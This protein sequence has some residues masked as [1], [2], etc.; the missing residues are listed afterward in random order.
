MSKSQRI[1]IFVLS[2]AL[3]FVAYW[4]S[5]PLPQVS[6]EIQVLIF[7]A[8]IM[9]SFTSL[10]LEH[11]FTTPTDVVA[12]TV[13]IL[14]VLLPLR[15]ILRPMA[16]YYTALV[17][18]SLLLLVTSM[19][20]LLLLDESAAST[21]A[22]NRASRS[23]KR[24]S[25]FFGRGK[26]L[27]VA[28]FFLAL[29]FFVQSTSR[30]FLVLSGYAAVIVLIDPARYVASSAMPARHRH[31]DVGEII[32]V[33]AK[34]T[35]IVKLFSKRVALRR[36]DIVEFRYAMDE[37]QRC[38][39]GLIIDNYLLNQQQWVKVLATEETTF[40]LGGDMAA[41]APKRNVLYKV[42]EASLPDALLRLAGVVTE[43]TTIGTLRFE[44][45]YRAP[46]AE[47][48]LVEVLVAG[49]RVL[50]QVVDAVTDMQLLESK[51]QTGVVVAQ[52]SQLGLW[53]PASGGFERYGWV[54]E[55][56][57]PVF[58]ASALD[59][60]E[61][62][63]THIVIGTLPGTTV[64][65]T[66]DTDEPLVHHLA[67]LGVT[68]TGKSVLARHI[69][70]Q[71]AN[72]GTKVICV[73][74]TDEYG[75]RMGD[76][77]PAPI[78]AADEQQPI[79][80]AIDELG[81]EA[82]K[83]RNQQTPGRIPQLEQDIRTRFDRAI[84]AFL[85]SEAS[86]A[87]FPL[88]DVSNT[89]GILDYTKW[90]FRVLFEIARRDREQKRRLCIVIE[91]A[92]TIVPETSFLGAEERRAQ[93]LVNSI[94]QIA[95]QGRKYG[96]GFIVVAQRTANVSKTVL[97]QCNSIIAFRQFDKT[98]ADFLANYAGT[99][100]VSALPNLRH[101]QAIAVGKAFRSNVPIIFEVLDIP[102]VEL[103]EA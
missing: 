81:L 4:A 9:A 29:V 67:I 76:P 64:P 78:V 60:P 42:E 103:R 57:T 65:I 58:L 45:A 95:L 11:F 22:R 82:S 90:F 70:R 68:G 5:K 20:A 30:A 75:R 77:P 85:A 37:D 55:V 43:G 80:Q 14:L 87:L 73:D 61:V 66:F 17:L 69:A 92:H 89:T 38:L 33:Q 98:S 3:L 83:F 97:T 79:F 16:P 46:L 39:R 53:D 101:R 34:S 86:V 56:N 25:T 19:S 35:F 84:T 102:E 1:L 91:E 36:F 74:F 23:L 96:V 6:P 72:L 8:L 24:F 15:T 27:Y 50:Y 18:Y 21:S 7:S 100:L 32:G 28:L 41:P 71:I 40:M 94:S 93:S 47:G 88:P 13:S 62:P 10:L 48:D 31:F 63:E 49:R 59:V 51:N 52:A 26:F 2:L 54:P 12:T 44:Y 99:Q